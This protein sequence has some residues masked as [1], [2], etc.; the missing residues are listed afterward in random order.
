MAIDSSALFVHVIVGVE[1]MTRGGT[2]RPLP[3]LMSATGTKG[4]TSTTYVLDAALTAA[5]EKVGT[6]TGISISSPGG[7]HPATRTSALHRGLPSSHEHRT[8][9]S[10]FVFP[11]RSASGS[12]RAGGPVIARSGP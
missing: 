7:V 4:R 12:Q 3:D 6:L 8:I 10:T 11:T 2:P 1:T 9:A 5:G